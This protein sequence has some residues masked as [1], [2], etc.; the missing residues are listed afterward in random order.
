MVCG[1]ANECGN[2]TNREHVVQE[3]S[4]SLSLYLL[5]II[6]FRS[7]LSLTLSLSFILGQP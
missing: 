1:E 6:M 3:L 4:F 5:L 7:V 2:C